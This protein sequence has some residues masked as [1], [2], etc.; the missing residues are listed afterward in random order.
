MKRFI[1]WG[2]AAALLAPGLPA[3][4]QAAPLT[5]GETLRLARERNLSALASEKRVASAEALQ[6]AAVSP[7]W[8][9]IGLQVGSGVTTGRSIGGQVFQPGLTVDT[10]LNANQLIYDWG[11]ARG[12]L[13]IAENQAQIARLTQEAAQQD[14][15]AAAGVGY[16]QVLRAEALNAVQEKVVAQAENHLRLAEMR[17]KAGTGTRS[18]TLQLQARLANAR[19]ALSQARNAVTI[20][21]LTLSN[22][23]N[24]PLGTRALAAS[25]PVPTQRVAEHEVAQRRAARPEVRAQALRADSDARRAAVER[26]AVYPG[27]SGIARY[28]QRNV[29]RPELFGGLALN[30][31]L[32]DASR[33]RNRAQSAEADLAADRILLEQAQL[34]AELDIRQQAQTRDEARARIDSAKAGLAAAQEA[35]RI[36]VRRFELGLATQYELTDVQNTLIQA[37]NDAIQAENDRAIAEIRLLRALHYDL[38]STLTP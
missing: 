30:W 36:A 32:F 27:V 25:A 33:S 37:E 1:L 11:A 10:S 20:A 34:A 5:L 4:A 35:Y 9:S 23:L 31:S 17:L 13:D 15:M 7:L 18:E 29:D 3:H 16:F 24:M 21:R 12:T 6:A 28:S 38:A 8:P 14:A 19:T 2:M 26:T 22:A